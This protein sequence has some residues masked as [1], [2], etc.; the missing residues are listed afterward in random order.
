M[1]LR[2]V[3]IV[4]STRGCSPG[5][6]A[7]VM[8]TTGHE[9]HCLLI[10]CDFAMIAK[11]LESFTSLKVL[12]LSG[13]IK[14][15][16]PHLPVDDLSRSHQVGSRNLTFRFWKKHMCWVFWTLNSLFICFPYG[17][18]YIILEMMWITFSSQTWQNYARYC[19]QVS[20]KDWKGWASIKS[21]MVNINLFQNWFK[22]LPEISH[23]K[24][25]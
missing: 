8:S 14:T 2:L 17:Y 15:G 5:R 16:V 13:T 12:A 19:L 22:T 3:Y 18:G 7:A 10:T 1:I 11:C 20:S 23:M 24:W 9:N 4:L 6:P 21:N 25:S